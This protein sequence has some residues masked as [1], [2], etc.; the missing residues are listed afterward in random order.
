MPK[1]AADDEVSRLDS[2][3]QIFGIG[4]VIFDASKPT[5]PDF[6]I[7]VRPS[8]HEPDLFYTNKYLA[9]IEKELFA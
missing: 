2:L 9:K 4:L 5:D 1:Q 7:M 3:C 8:K 6:R